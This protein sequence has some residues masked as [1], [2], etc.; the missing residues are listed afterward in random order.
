MTDMFP[1]L[2]SPLALRHLRLKNR[3]TFGAHTANMS[4]NGLPGARHLGY[5]L[6][7]A[8]GGC[9]MIV[10]EPV[11]VHATAVLTRG[12]FRHDSDDVIAPFRRLTDACHEHGTAM[13]QQL[14]HVGA[15]GDAANSWVANWSPSGAASHHD[16][17][18]SHAMTEAEIEAVLDGFVQAGRRAMLAGFDGVELFAAYNALIDQFWS[19]LSNRR[20]DRWGGPLENRLRFA[21][22]II[23]GI[24]RHAGQDF[25][26]GMA[27]S[28]AE[29][30]PGGLSL[31]DKAEICAWLDQ[32]G[33]IDYFTVG[34]GSYLNHFERIVPSF[35]TEPLLGAA[36]AAAIRRAVRHARVQAEARIRTPANGEQV[37]ASGQADL[38]S[39]VRAQIADADLA[40]KALAG[41]AADI[42]PCIDCNQECIGRRL[43]DYWISCLVNPSVGREFVWAEPEAGRSARPK[44]VL[45]VGGG[46]AGMETARVAAERG[47]RVTLIERSEHLGGQL[48]LAAR[49][50]KREEI[51]EFLAWLE[52]QLT[53]LQVEI[54]RGAEVSADAIAAEEYDQVVIA[55]GA[56]P[57]ASGFQRALPHVA[58][59]PGVELGHVASVEDVLSG[60]ATPGPRVLLVDDDGG[61][62]ASGTAL[63]LAA[64]GHRVTVLTPA[65][66][67]G[68]HL[69]HTASLG[70]MAKALAQRDVTVITSSAVS[71][72]ERDTVVILDLLSGRE[73]RERFDAVVLATL[74]EA[75]AELAA[76]LDA[77]GIAATAIGDCVAPRKATM[78]LYEAR[79][80]ALE[81]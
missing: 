78:A 51:D 43:R 10:V 13:I 52:R 44:R 63:Y 58:R 1:H 49:Q 5:Y 55:T 81:L 80:L 32:R 79:R 67:V 66:H 60:R 76:Q 6:A 61:W 8:R 4:E 59:L 48:R 19:P 29:P 69:G 54:R 25:V 14:Y 16:G 50:P 26:I 38:V 33:L 9:A 24:R 71:A 23:E 53:Q 17:D 21:V 40:N 28:G 57:G 31:A 39:L 75:N 2:F 22:R 46:P 70:L 20:A 41:R 12:N 35:L 56:R 77:R 37:I 11:P 73:R 34:T 62:R 18:G 3:I 27:I 47:H 72:I 74:P 42:R 15:H 45:V 36:D 64:R 30:Y 68:H 7:R 65:L